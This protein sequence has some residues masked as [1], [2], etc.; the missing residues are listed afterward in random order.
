MVWWLVKGNES[1]STAQSKF[2]TT[3]NLFLSHLIDVVIHPFNR[4]IEIISC[5]IP[6]VNFTT[7]AIS[8]TLQ[9]SVSFS[10][11]LFLSVNLSP[12]SVYSP[13]YIHL[14][15]YNINWNIICV[16]SPLNKVIWTNTPFHLWLAY[17]IL[18]ACKAGGLNGRESTVNRGLDG[19]IYP[20]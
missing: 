16:W 1:H 20:G 15:S 6:T 5:S 13:L 7:H 17:N 19:S 3:P 14:P 10:V 12:F 9:C 18:F 4:V 2:K 11:N 8:V